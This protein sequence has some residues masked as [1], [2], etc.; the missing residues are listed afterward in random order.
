[1]VISWRAKHWISKSDETF[2]RTDLQ[3]FKPQDISGTESSVFLTFPHPERWR[4]SNTLHLC[5]LCCKTSGRCRSTSR[6]QCRTP[7]DPDRGETQKHGRIIVLSCTAGPQLTGVYSPAVGVRAVACRCAWL[8][9][10]WSESPA[11]GVKTSHNLYSF[12]KILTEWSKNTWKRFVRSPG[13]HSA[14]GSRGFHLLCRRGLDWTPEAGP[15]PPHTP[16][17]A[18]LQ[19]PESFTWN[20]CHCCSIKQRDRTLIS[21][22]NAESM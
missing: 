4:C 19:H 17:E 18:S 21:H 22:S 11:P 8:G 10:V 3:M 9:E 12:E 7:P 15:S 1:M 14:A 6:S 20:E 13:I 5:W 2:C 16:C